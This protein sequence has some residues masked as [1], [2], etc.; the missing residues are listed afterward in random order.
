[1][2]HAFNEIIIA[3]H[4]CLDLT[5]E[6]LTSQTNKLLEPG[7]LT[8]VGPLA[9]NPGGAVANTGLALTK[10][11]FNVELIGKIGNDMVGDLLS[12]SLNSIKK[13][14]GDHLIK[15]DLETTSYSIVL[16]PPRIDRSFLHNPGANHS[17]EFA[18]L[19]KTLK[20]K[21]LHFGYPP[22]MKQMYRGNGQELLAIL[23]WAKR[24]G[25][26]TS[27]DMAMPDQDA[28]DDAIDWNA[29]LKNVLKSVD[30]FIPSFE[31]TLALLRKKTDTSSN[32]PISITMLQ[33][34]A[35]LCLDYGCSIVAFKLGEYGLYLKTRDKL[36]SFLNSNWKHTE[37]FV[38]C[39]KVEVIGTTGAGDSTISGLIA[40]MLRLNQPEDAV[41]AAV[42]TGALSVTQK[43]AT[44]G[45]KDWETIMNLIQ[46]P[47]KNR[48][49][50]FN[51][52][53]EWDFIKEKGLWRLK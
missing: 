14:L 31:E 53:S 25:K 4:I 42:A 10:L 47:Q 38:P 34:L 23:Q 30:L 18:N 17:F 44:S 1:M 29:I 20:G 2:D 9:V 7:G 32:S 51:P 43:D 40:G 3:G 48:L 46:S 16:N 12:K 49:F 37:L 52:G 5:P 36:P 11:G 22:L 15:E 45:I 41:N 28:L 24:S 39:F 6:I 8:K 19:P 13:G 27:L 26:I 50:L 35:D 21:W 33:E